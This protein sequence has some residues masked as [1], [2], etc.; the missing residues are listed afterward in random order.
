[1]WGCSVFLFS[2]MHIC[3]YVCVCVCVCVCACVCVCMCRSLWVND[4][5]PQTI[6][7]SSNLAFCQSM[8]TVVVKLKLLK[9]CSRTITQTNRRK[10]SKRAIATVFTTLFFTHTLN[11]CI[12][13]P[14]CIT[15]THTHTHTHSLSLTH[16]HTHTQTTT[17]H[18]HT[19]THR[20]TP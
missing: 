14:Q 16:T 19:H 10:A 9:K 18:I 5:P 8:I 7:N 3:V 1:R 12:T 6:C 11:H 17:L 20:H 4:Y 15:V 13:I 2:K